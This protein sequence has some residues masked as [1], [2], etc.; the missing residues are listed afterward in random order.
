MAIPVPIA[1]RHEGARS[2]LSDFATDVMPFAKKMGVTFPVFWDDGGKTAGTWKVA[3]MPTGIV[4][5][6]KGA[7]AY[8][9]RG[10]VDGDEAAL[11]K[12]ITAALAE[13]AK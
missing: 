11:E 10:F 13:P 12:A 2:E 9:Q 6:K 8:T 1:D 3:T 7:L 4:V 5:N